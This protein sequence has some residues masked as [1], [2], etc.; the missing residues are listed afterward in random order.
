M[1]NLQT[2]EHG[3]ATSEMVAGAMR[4]KPLT[5]NEQ[6][7]FGRVA[8]LTSQTLDLNAAW[9]AFQQERS[10]T[11]CPTSLSSDYAQ[12]QKWLSRCPVTELDR[13]REVMSWV[14]SQQPQKAARRVGMYV[15]TL[16]RWAASEDVALV[17]RNPV[18]SFKFPKR[19]QGDDEVVVIPRSELLFLLAGMTSRSRRTPL[20]RCVVE[21]MLQTGARTGEAFAA[22]WEDISGERLLIHQNMTLTHGLKASTKTNRKRWVPLNAAVRGTLEELPHTSEFLFP[23]NR[24][25][26]QS[27]FSDR[28]AKL[29]EQGVISQ[30]Y[31]PYDLRHTAISGW[32]EA[33]IPVTQAA[34]WA[35]NSAEVIWKHYANTTTDYEMPVL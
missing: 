21:F 15:K 30:R 12:V 23:W 26:F 28:V 35:G 18:A 5:L 27:F 13:G 19:P 9:A 24:V 32:L 4:A 2:T 16:Y 20:W 6:E 25:S 14:L 31:R 34:A 1:H 10:V 8:V 7:F 33:G 17:S 22:R 3:V 29:A 11:L